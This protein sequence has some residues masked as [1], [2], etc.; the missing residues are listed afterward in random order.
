[1]TDKRIRWK[2]W[3]QMLL[4]VGGLPI[5]M[6]GCKKDG[7]TEQTQAAIVPEGP[8]TE[9]FPLAVGARWV[10][11]YAYNRSQT[12]YGNT[13][14]SWEKGT[15]TFTV[16]TVAN[17]QGRRRWTVREQDDLQ[18][19]DSSGGYGYPLVT[20][21]Y[22]LTRDFTVF[23]DEDTTGLHKL[24]TEYCSLLWLSPVATYFNHDHSYAL[25]T[26]SLFRYVRDSVETSLTCIGDTSDPGVLPVTS[27][28]DTLEFVRNKGLVRYWLYFFVGGSAHQES[29]HYWGT[30]RSYTP[31]QAAG[32]ILRRTPYQ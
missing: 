10:Y 7:P 27:Y 9:V 32:A 5:A 23:S 15:I 16:Q 3:L 28:R 2:T 11:D 4:L 24:S 13:K 29:R 22:P 12:D 31:G 14:N 25:S 18:Y 20:H 26:T 17:E 8:R 19:T 30:L 21:A 1:M 6:I